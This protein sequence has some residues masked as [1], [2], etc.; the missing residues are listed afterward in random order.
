MNTIRI[1]QR[2]YKICLLLGL[3]YYGT[4]TILIFYVENL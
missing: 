4:T 3:I 1:T 2:E